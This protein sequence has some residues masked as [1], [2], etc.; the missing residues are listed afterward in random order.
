MSVIDC[1]LVLVI[2]LSALAPIWHWKCELM[3]RSQKIQILGRVY[4]TCKLHWMLV[5]VLTNSA[6]W[7]FVL[8]H[9]DVSS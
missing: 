4:I 3:L 8:K 5:H 6:A 7:S 9:V 1:V 2:L